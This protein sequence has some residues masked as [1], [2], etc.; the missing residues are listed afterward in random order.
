[1]HN[2][3][4]KPSIKTL[5]FLLFFDIVLIVQG[6]QSL[7]NAFIYITFLSFLLLILSYFTDYLS[8][9]N[10][11][12]ETLYTF[13]SFCGFPVFSSFVV[14]Y[15]NFQTEAIFLFFVQLNF[16]TFYARYKHYLKSVFIGV[17]IGFALFSCSNRGELYQFSSSL[18]KSYALF[19][20]SILASV[21]LWKTTYTQLLSSLNAREIE[22]EE[23]MTMIVH[24]LNSPLANIDL[25]ARNLKKNY[26]N[27]ALIEKSMNTIIRCV[28][29]ALFQIQFRKENLRTYMSKKNAQ[30]VDI[31]CF[32]HE[33]V[34]NYVNT[35]KERVDIDIRGSSFFI[36]ADTN[37]LHSIFTNLLNNA[38][39][40]I[41][42]TGKGSITITLEAS[43]KKNTIRFNDTS[44]GVK[45]D[46][47]PFIFDKGFSRRRDGTGMG[48]YMCAEL[49]HHLGGTIRCES[50]LG[51]FTEFII[52]FPI[53]KHHARAT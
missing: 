18:A 2:K 17:I 22:I 26:K 32:I 36:H 41:K 50:V 12:Q 37:F 46:V 53:K 3:H 21:F 40:F 43:T 24:E 23:N 1:M 28:Q 35:Y 49:I 38:C 51:E 5:F 20:F 11:T 52:E 10:A 42:K 9:N 15:E 27:D 48:L 44:I 8:K 13:F 29:R 4:L 7:N 19:I 25:Y 6:D 14:F 16:Y 31:K 33:C 47:L 34:R 39:F 45:P 30:D